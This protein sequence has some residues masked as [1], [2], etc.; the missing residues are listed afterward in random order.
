MGV[1]QV[2]VVDPVTRSVM[3]FAGT[4]M[5]EQNGGELEVPETP[6][7]IALADIFKILDRRR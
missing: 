7:V 4:T 3:V 5:F 1:V 6:V 2:W